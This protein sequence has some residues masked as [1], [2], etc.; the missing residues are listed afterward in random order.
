MSWSCLFVGLHPVSHLD[1]VVGVQMTER[2]FQARLLAF[3]AARNRAKGLSAQLEAEPFRF[4]LD[5]VLRQAREDQRD[6]ALDLFEFGNGVSFDAEWLEQLGLADLAARL[7]AI[8][9]Q[10]GQIGQ[11]WM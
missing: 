3:E 8:S 11:N 1:A 9:R 7:A 4:E 2:G 6:L 10:A 5:E